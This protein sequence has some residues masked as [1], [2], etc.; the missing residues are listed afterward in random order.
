M[1]CSVMGCRK[2][3]D[4]DTN[5]AFYRLPKLMPEHDSNILAKKVTDDRRSLWIQRIKSNLPLDRIRVCSEHFVSGKYQ[6]NKL[7]ET[8]LARN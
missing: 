7:F 8:F 3:S 4:R 1:A 6:S 2:R 5:V